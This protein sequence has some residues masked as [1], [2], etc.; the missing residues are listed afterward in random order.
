MSA[1][2]VAS[3]GATTI[4]MVMGRSRGPTGEA[5]RGGKSAGRDLRHGALDLAQLRRRGDRPVY[6]ADNEANAAAPVRSVTLRG[7]RRARP[8]EILDIGERDD[9]TTVPDL[10]RRARP[11]RAWRFDVA[12]ARRGIERDD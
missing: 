2:P 11:R 8:D 9:T 6:S 12:P 3:S 5:P 1:K 4:S 10:R 7:R